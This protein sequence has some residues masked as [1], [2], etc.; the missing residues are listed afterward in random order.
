MTFTKCVIRKKTKGKKL[1][2]C[3]QTISNR[4][5]KKRGIF[6]AL[7]SFLFRRNFLFEMDLVCFWNH[8]SQWRYQSVDKMRGEHLNGTQNNMQIVATEKREKKKRIIPISR[9]CSREIMLYLK[10]HHVGRKK[11]RKKENDTSSGRSCYK[12]PTNQGKYC[13]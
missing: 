5:I 4:F 6:V 12:K 8:L 9:A 1:C 3:H 13:R 2:E 10:T 11:R 7:V